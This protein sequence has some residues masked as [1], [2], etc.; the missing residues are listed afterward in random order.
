M[1]LF[2]QAKRGQAWREGL[3]PGSGV[4]RGFAVPDEK[5]IVAALHGITTQAPVR[6]M[7]TPGGFRM[8]VVDDG[9]LPAAQGVNHGQTAA[10]ETT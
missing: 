3:Y 4:P 9:H 10:S 8:S 1:N 5:A 2:G 7:V 6:H